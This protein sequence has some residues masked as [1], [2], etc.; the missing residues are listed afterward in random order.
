L[1][2]DSKLTRFAVDKTRKLLYDKWM[3]NTL[4]ANAQVFHVDFDNVK[5]KDQY[6]QQVID[7]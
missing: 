6:E 1:A 7:E 2:K 5:L 3:T 4:G